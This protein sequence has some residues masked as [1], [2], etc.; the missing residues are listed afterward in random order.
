MTVKYKFRSK[1]LLYPALDN[2]TER[3][4]IYTLSTIRIQGPLSLESVYNL[5]AHR[6]K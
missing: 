3:H 5:T 4:C 2:E 6:V 1:V